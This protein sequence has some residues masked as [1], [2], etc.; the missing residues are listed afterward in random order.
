DLSGERRDGHVGQI[1]Q[2]DGDDDDVAGPGGFRWRHRARVRPELVDKLGE[3]LRAA[4]VAD[5][6]VITVLHRQPRELTADVAGADQSESLHVVPRLDP[7]A[8]SVSS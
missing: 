1:L 7:T 3:R 2:R 6:D 4:R 8:F 5:D